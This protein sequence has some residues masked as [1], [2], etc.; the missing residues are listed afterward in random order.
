MSNIKFAHTEPEIRRCWMVMQE[1]RPRLKE[2]N[3]VSQI[4]RQ[5]QQGYQL[6]FIEENGLVVSAAGFRISEFLE[7]GKMLYIDDLITLP[8]YRRK[9][10]GGR[11]IDFLVAFADNNSCQ[12]IHLDSGHARYDAHR[13][14]LDKGF[15]I[16]GHH[17]SI[18]LKK[19]H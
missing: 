2:D 17:L 13:L 18:L 1:L 6:I 15:K 9:G 11:L 4:L 7:W 14:Y 19:N 10:Y 8:A 5:H 3:F 16:T 12:Q